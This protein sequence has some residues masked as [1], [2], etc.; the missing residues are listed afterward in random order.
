ML[1]I[2]LKNSTALHV[3]VTDVPNP[4]AGLITTNGAKIACEL[5]TTITPILNRFIRRVD[6]MQRLK[7]G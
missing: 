6:L 5:K 4:K 2:N 1:I 3:I 7:K